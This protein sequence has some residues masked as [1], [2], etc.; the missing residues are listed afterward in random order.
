M[1]KKKR[2]TVIN[3]LGGICAMILTQV[4]SYLILRYII[5]YPQNCIWWLHLK[6]FSKCSNSFWVVNMKIIIVEQ[7]DGKLWY[8]FQNIM[9]SHDRFN[10]GESGPCAP[11][12]AF[13][14]APFRVILDIFFLTQVSTISF[15]RKITNR[16]SLF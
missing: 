7:N 12:S 1:L 3:Y 14:G 9:P 2:S 15:F 8:C 10:S 11:C 16:A 6:R 4:Y 13:C 5:N